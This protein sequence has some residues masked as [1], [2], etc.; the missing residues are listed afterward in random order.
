[1]VAY[2]KPQRWKKEEN[3]RL[4]GEENKIKLVDHK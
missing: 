2:T 1:M 3:E 4:R